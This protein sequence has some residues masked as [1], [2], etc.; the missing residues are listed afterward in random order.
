MGNGRPSRKVAHLTLNENVDT[1]HIYLAVSLE[2]HSPN[3]FYG[4]SG[5]KQHQKHTKKVKGCRFHMAISNVT[6]FSSIFDEFS[7]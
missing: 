4:Q 5:T 3:Q 1:L 2:R 6:Q 7:G